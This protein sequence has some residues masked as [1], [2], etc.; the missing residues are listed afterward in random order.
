MEQQD[1]LGPGQNAISAQLR[2]LTRLYEQGR[3]DDARKML[4]K[5]AEEASV[6]QAAASLVPDPLLY[7]GALVAAPTGRGKSFALWSSAEEAIVKAHRDSIRVRVVLYCS[8]DRLH[9]APEDCIIADRPD[10]SVWDTEPTYVLIR[11]G[12]D[13]ETGAPAVG[14]ADLLQLASPG[15]PVLFYIDEI[16]VAM[17]R[18]DTRG[19]QAIE[20][21]LVSGRTSTSTRSPCAIRGAVQRIQQVPPKLAEVGFHYKWI[22]PYDDPRA[23]ERLGARVVLP[24]QS[25]PPGT[26][27]SCAE[28]RI[29]TLPMSYDRDL[30]HAHH[31]AEWGLKRGS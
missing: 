10:P 21:A 19:L 16:G 9:S 1:F 7:H 26:F 4:I 20:Y 18:L 30:I 13:P 5:L 27:Y 28:R 3:E 17:S 12:L 29:V 24:S 15:D 2:K 14:M 31:G 11:P 25:S 22:G 23:A 8:L 6:G